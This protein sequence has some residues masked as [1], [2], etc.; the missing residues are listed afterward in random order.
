MKMREG[1]LYK[2]QHATQRAEILSGEGKGLRYFSLFSQAKGTSTSKRSFT[3]IRIS[4]SEASQGQLLL[5][6][7]PCMKLSLVNR[8]LSLNLVF[9]LI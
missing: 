1:S 4:L 6:H 9:Q 5:T 2:N 7:K 3:A 8:S